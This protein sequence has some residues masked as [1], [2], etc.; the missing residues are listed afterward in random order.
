MF[1]C[2]KCLRSVLYI[3]LYIYSFKD[4][5]YIYISAYIVIYELLSGLGFI[6]LNIYKT[7]EQSRG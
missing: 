4:I 2:N 7:I 3:V 1:A 6:V 5:I